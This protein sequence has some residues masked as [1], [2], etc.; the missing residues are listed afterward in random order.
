M[1][2]DNSNEDDEKTRLWERLQDLQKKEKESLESERKLLEE[3]KATMANVN[4]EP[5]DIITIN[6][7]GERLIQCHRSTLCLAE[8]SVFSSLFSGRW[9]D[10]VARDK[11]GNVFFDHDPEL[12]VLIINYLRVRKI[13]D[14][15]KDGCSFRAKIPDGKRSDFNKLLEY[16]GLREFF[17]G[18]GNIQLDGIQFSQSSNIVTIQRDQRVASMTYD[19]SGHYWV[20]CKLP[21]RTVCYWKVEITSLPI[22]TWFYAGVI[23]RDSPPTASHSDPTSFGW[24]GTSQVYIAGIAGQNQ[25][26][27]D[28]WS[29]FSQGETL[30]FCLQNS[31]LMMYSASKNRL[32]VIDGVTIP[33]DEAYIHFNFHWSGTQISLSEAS[34]DDRI[35]LK[36][37]IPN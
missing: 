14:P 37:K 30:I 33:D 32:F 3:E 24:G 18:S 35:A 21:N 6:V 15:D 12:I 16:F 7:G 20:T 5:S 29:A 13:G 22:T 25:N 23:G 9:E 1:D 27:H 17:F 4:V 19:G 26:G 28:G 2:I 34:A 8:G 36:N 11:D 31:K 10:S